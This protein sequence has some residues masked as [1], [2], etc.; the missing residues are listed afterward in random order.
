MNTRLLV[1][2]VILCAMISCSTSEIAVRK[3]SLKQIKSVAVLPFTVEKGISEKAGL[4]CM[5]AFKSHMI[6]S[7][8]NL[9]ERQAI[10]KILKEKELAMSGLTGSKSM[11]IGQL[12]SADGL[13]T[14]NVTEYRDE[15]VNAD[16]KLSPFGPDAY[17]PKKDS[18]DGSFF[19]KNGEWFKKTKLRI[20][21]FQIFVRLISA[22]DGQVV[23]TLQN[24]Y[25]AAKF[26]IDQFNVPGG[27][28][29][30]VNRV[31]QQ[32]GKDLKKALK[33]K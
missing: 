1:P 6:Q 17:D 16:V 5:E 15:T 22:K 21:Y 32:M 26:E 9:V 30:H 4:D 27:M 3:G 33:E 11:E 12:L 31:L 18:K 2:T 19:Q 8:F 7:G 20:F 28:D 10:D 29:D 25:P 14:G 23:F 13:L 24:S